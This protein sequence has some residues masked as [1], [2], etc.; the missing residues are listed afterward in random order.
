MSHPMTP[1][2][3][4]EGTPRTA[5]ALKATHGMFRVAAACNGFADH[6]R[7][8]ERENQ[9]LARRV[10]ELEGL[11]SRAVKALECADAYFYNTAGQKESVE[12]P[13]TTAIRATL[14]QGDKA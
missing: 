8:L 13:I 12:Q 4:N 9:S 6:A 1:H 2:A 10:G 7:T 11:L 3:S 14:N 5:K